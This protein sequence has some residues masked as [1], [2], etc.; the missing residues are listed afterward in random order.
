MDSFMRGKLYMYGEKLRKNTKKKETA[1]DERI[2]CE[3]EIEL[4]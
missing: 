4:V 1:R 2:N 3:S